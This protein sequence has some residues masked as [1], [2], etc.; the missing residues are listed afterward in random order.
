MPDHNLAPR[1]DMSINVGVSADCATLDG[2]HGGT[3][4]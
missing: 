1:Q 4:C 3:A 2:D